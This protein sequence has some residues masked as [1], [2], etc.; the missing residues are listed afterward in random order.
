MG[1][2]K[3]WIDNEKIITLYQTHGIDGVKK[4]FTADAFVSEIGLASDV[5]DMVLSNKHDIK[6]WNSVTEMIKKHVK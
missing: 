2:H 3:R 5:V 1:F 6:L 4:L